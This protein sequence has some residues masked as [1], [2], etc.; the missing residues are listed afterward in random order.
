MRNNLFPP[1][2]SIINNING[3]LNILCGLEQLIPS[4]G[5]RTD[6]Y[7]IRR[8]LTTWKVSKNSD[9][10]KMRIKYFCRNTYT[11]NHVKTDVP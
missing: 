8:T 2:F 3:D 6:N 10:L 9:L 7:D 11:C 1:L 4:S 5:T